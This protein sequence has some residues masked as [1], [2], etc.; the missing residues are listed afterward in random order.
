MAA[1]SCLGSCEAG[2]VG[3]DAAS[4]ILW[5]HGLGLVSVA[6]KYGDDVLDCATLLLL[7]GWLG[8]GFM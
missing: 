1:G 3:E 7:Q 8:S 2:C 6:L 4:E 5:H